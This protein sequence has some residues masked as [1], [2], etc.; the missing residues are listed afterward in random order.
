MRYFWPPRAKLC[1][2]WESLPEWEAKKKW[3]AQRKFNGTH[4]LIH[5]LPSGEVE[6]FNRHGER[7]RQFQL[8]DTLRKEILSLHFQP[9][10]EY[11]IDSELL[12]AKTTTPAYKSK[13]VM[14][15]MLFAGK[16]LFLEN[17]MGRLDILRAICR[18][19]EELEP[20]AGIALRV[21]DNLWMAETFFS[22]FILEY[23]R[24]IDR[25]EIEGLVL[26][27]I[28]ANLTVGGGKEE[29]VDWI[30]R[31]RKPHKNYAF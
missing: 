13:I 7:H 9:G 26:R 15:D 4:N 11:W 16:S 19:P 5:V 28:R 25:S 21:T 8:S 17:Q 3:V 22:N 18:D 20:N 29:T 30:L 27:D 31:C 24:F 23:K 1:I 12:D 2:N 6:L 10:L 14:F